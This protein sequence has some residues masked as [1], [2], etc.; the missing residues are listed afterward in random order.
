MVDEIKNKVLVPG[1]I[2]EKALDLQESINEYEQILETAYKRLQKGV[3]Y[4]NLTD[5]DKRST[6]KKDGAKESNKDCLLQSGA[7]SLFIWFCLTPEFEYKT[8][9]I[10]IPG[11][12]DIISVDCICK[13]VDLKGRVRGCMLGNANSGEKKYKRDFDWLPE[14]TLGDDFDTS[15]AE[16]KTV[17]KKDG[18]TFRKFRVR[19]TV[20]PFD[21]LNTLSKMA[22]KR[23]FVGASLMATGM[24]RFFTQDLDDAID[25]IDKDEAE[26]GRGHSGS[27]EKTPGKTDTKKESGQPKDLADAKAQANKLIDSAY[28]SKKL[29][30]EGKK[31][32]ATNVANA[33]AKSIGAVL[34][35]LRKIIGGVNHP[36]STEPENRPTPAP[37]SDPPVDLTDLRTACKNALVRLIEFE[38]IGKEYEADKLAKIEAAD[39]AGL[40]A[41][42]ADYTKQLPGA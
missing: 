21:L 18:G 14:W 29:N 1:K 32:W 26:K 38:E 39:E 15:T 2:Y 3:D 27:S 9:F 8:S 33:N 22:N 40:K 30:D 13:A 12:P 24:S 10:P 17:A 19:A 31:T 34:E 4:A 37:Q 7:Q 41:I 35:T 16:C 20:S 28:A 42:L 25:N 23:S 6:D 5:R 36:N 11:E